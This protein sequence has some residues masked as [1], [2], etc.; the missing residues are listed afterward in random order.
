MKRVC[1]LECLEVICN[2]YKACSDWEGTTL[3]INIRSHCELVDEHG[4]SK[5]M[6]EV[7]FGTRIVA[8]KD[9]VVVHHDLADL[10]TLI[11]RG[12]LMMINYQRKIV[13][14]LMRRSRVGA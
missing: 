1:L 4:V 12:S 7:E 8:C 2:E 11:V 13:I 14:S 9:F 5:E 10:E 6:L 3:G